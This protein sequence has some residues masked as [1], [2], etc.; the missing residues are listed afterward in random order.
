M[1]HAISR[2][3]DLPV[4]LTASELSQMRG[5]ERLF[6]AF[7]TFAKAGSGPWPTSLSALSQAITAERLVV[8][9][10]LPIRFRVEMWT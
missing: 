5:I 6:S 2:L 4:G 7:T 10:D 8:S 9:R 1:T 3:T